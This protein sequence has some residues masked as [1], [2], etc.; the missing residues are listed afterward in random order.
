MQQIDNAGCYIW[1]FKYWLR[2][3]FPDVLLHHNN[4][5]MN[6]AKTSVKTPRGNQKMHIKNRQTITMAKVKRTDNNNGHK[7]MTDNNNGHK[8]KDRQ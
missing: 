6:V 1:S 8:K 4:N 5:T 3:L 7:K 2:S